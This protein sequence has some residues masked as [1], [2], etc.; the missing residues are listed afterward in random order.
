M[1]DEIYAQLR[2]IGLTEGEV[3][4]Y[5]ALL[6][7]GPC[8]IGPVTKKSGI[9]SSKIYQIINRLIKKGLASKIIQDNVRHFSAAPPERLQ[10]YLQD[11]QEEIKKQEEKL[12]Q[13]MPALKAQHKESASRRET[14]MYTG[15]EG[16]KT[17]VYEFISDI[18]EGEEHVVFGARGQL[19]P[20]S[21]RII[22]DFYLE[23]ERRGIKTRLVYNEEVRDIKELYAGLELVDLR[24]VKTLTPSTFGVKKGAFMTVSYAPEPVAVLVWHEALAENFYTF[25]DSIWNISKK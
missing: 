19:D 25:F 4:V 21:E 14:I 18:P 16:L 13:I 22:R 6:E 10:T 20:R 23:K 9:T 17:A 7:V 24:F 3:R 15:Y 8:T 11:K 2:N 5:F 1:Q 12:A